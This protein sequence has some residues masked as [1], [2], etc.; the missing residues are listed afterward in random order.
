MPG[1]KSPHAVGKHSAPLQLQ[2]SPK[3]LPNVGSSMKISLPTQPVGDVRRRFVCFLHAV[4]ASGTDVTDRIDYLL[5]HADQPCAEG[6]SR[7]LVRG[8]QV[9]SSRLSLVA[10][11]AGLRASRP[12][13]LHVRG[14]QSVPHGNPC[15]VPSPNMQWASTPPRFSCRQARRLCSKLESSI[16]VRISLC[17]RLCLK[18]ETFAPYT[19]C[20]RPARR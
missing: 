19:L 10:L 2:A 5:Y 8:R 11:L 15:P 9:P 13:R 4:Y 6:A 18:Y 17:D 12:T 16:S 7:A 3:D 1:S 20:M 14:R